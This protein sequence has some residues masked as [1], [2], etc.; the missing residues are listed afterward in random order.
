MRKSNKQLS[1]EKIFLDF[2]AKNSNLNHSCPYEVSQNM[3]E[4]T[5]LLIAYIFFLGGYNCK[6]PD[7]QDRVPEVFTAANWPV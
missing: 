2:V 1:Y 5:I 3:Q 4:N 7:I 6:R